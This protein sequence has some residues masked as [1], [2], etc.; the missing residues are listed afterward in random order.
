[1]NKNLLEVVIN[2][3]DN[4]SGG[5]DRMKTRSVT[6][7]Q[8]IR[9]SFNNLGAG[10]K[11]AIFNVRGLIAAFAALAAVRGII[12]FMREAAAAAAEQERAVNTLNAALAAAGEFS[13]EASE[14]LQEYAAALQESLGIGDEVTIETLGMIEGLTKLSAEALPGAMDAVV[15]ISNLYQVD[16]KNAALL[17]GKTLTSNLNAFQRYGIQVDMSADAQGRLNQILSATSAGMVIAEAKMLTFDGQTGR[18]RNSWGDFMEV[19]GSWITESPVVVNV[20]KLIGDWVNRLTGS[21]QDGKTAGQD[22]VGK[23]FAAIVSGGI[24]VARGIIGLIRILT[25]AW[26]GIW[27]LERGL[28]IAANAVLVF[29]RDAI[30][31]FLTWVEGTI[32]AGID[33]INRFINW[34][35]NTLKTS[36]STMTRIT[37][38]GF[39]GL[40]NAIA[41]TSDMVS[42]ASE[43]IDKLHGFLIDLDGITDT[44]IGAQ[45]ELNNV[46]E[47]AGGTALSTADDFNNLAGAMNNVNDAVSGGG[48]ADSIS[49]INDELERTGVNITALMAL[50]SFAMMAQEAERQEKMAAVMAELRRIEN[51]PF[52]DYLR[53]IGVLRPDPIQSAIEGVYQV[54]SVDELLQRFTDNQA[55]DETEPLFSA[56]EDSIIKNTERLAESV[57]SGDIGSAFAKTFDSIGSVIATR[58]NDSIVKHFQT[59]EGTD[60]FGGSV[61]GALGSGLIGGAFGLIGGLFKKKKRKGESAADPLKVEVVNTGDIATAALNITK[62]FLLGLSAPGVDRLSAGLHFEAQRINAS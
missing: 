61:L 7:L 60:T 26:T 34:S 46:V 9:T 20:I 53:D 45:T 15:Q 19:I 22:L 58:V 50:L 25:L 3:R 62:S 5:I 38:D 27:E 40:D 55:A 54:P 18:L 47:A 41:S 31:G 33:Q 14:G 49:D 44:L 11:N 48:T 42:Q 29:L 59:A 56:L 16:Y 24:W 36:F 1:M 52:M 12:N 39:T 17:L 43:E 35:N 6:G 23:A 37:I 13:V 8:R 21:M 28:R 10:I 57:F 2:L 4:F 32:N 30:N 51:E